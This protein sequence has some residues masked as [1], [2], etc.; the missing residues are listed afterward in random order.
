MSRWAIFGAVAATAVLAACCLLPLFNVVSLSS[1]IADGDD[2]VAAV[3]F[4]VGGMMK[5]RSGAT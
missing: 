4:I 2:V 1:D 5:S 3:T